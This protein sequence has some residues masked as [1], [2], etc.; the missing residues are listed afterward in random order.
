MNANL[1]THFMDWA[2]YGAAFLSGFVTMAIEMLLGRTFTPYF[3]G[4]IHTWGALISVFLFGM[5]GGY[6]LGGRIADRSPRAGGLAVLFGA[7]AVLT[8]VIPLL[9]EPIITGILD[10]MEDVRY[11]AL[12]A[13]LGL[14]CLPAAALAAV[15]PFCVRLLLDTSTRSGTVSGRLSGLTTA[16][17]I[18][19]TL[20][21][22]FLLIP[23]FGTRSIYEGLS[24]ISAAAC[25]GFFV[26]ARTRGASFATAAIAII[27][28]S[29]AWAQDPGLLMK[30]DGQLEFVESEY[31][32]IYVLKK[33]SE[34]SLNFGYRNSRY[35]E[36]SMD[37]TKPDELTVE[38]T[39]TMSAAIAYKQGPIKKIALVGLGGG[40]TIKY[41]LASI[42]GSTADVAELDPAVARLA[43][44]Y[45][46][47]A[48]SDRLRVHE[49]DGRVFL[50]QSKEKFDLILLDA[51]RGPFVPFHLTTQEFYRLVKSRLNEG[52]V[53]AQNVE[54]S[55]LFFD[56]T[57]A[58]MKSIFDSVDALDAGGN[59]VLVGYAGPRLSSEALAARAGEVQ[60]RLAPR[61]DLRQIVKQ[62]RERVSVEGAKI[63]TDDFAPVESL[64]TIRRHNEKQR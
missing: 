7:A 51:Y 4:T 16:G 8:I 62:R 36:S 14:A 37:L 53:V 54:P 32:T 3:G 20:G 43:K 59:V 50:S 41:L 1:R 63:L 34:I 48:P 47:A 30:K 21:T 10:L 23:S 24:A 64:K 26:L 2:L 60:K 40:R 9:G 46:G 61:Y 17:S 45:F 58:T 31:N 35:G 5:T 18:A 39:R 33:G 25:I 13:A 12:V 49:K 6:V 38:Y 22:T 28:T 57:F 44:T 52:G 15:S 55:T 27:F 56:S 11:A 19:G 29:S 42:P